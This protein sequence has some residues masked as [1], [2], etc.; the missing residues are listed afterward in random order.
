MTLCLE[1][2]FGRRSQPMQVGDRIRSM[3][4]P[5]LYGHEI[6][7]DPPKT[8]HGTIDEVRRDNLLVTLDCGK[9]IV[10]YR[11]WTHENIPAAL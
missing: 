10:V 1:Q 7:V 3:T 6:Y 9:Q 4:C 5:E 2:T 8:S 11:N